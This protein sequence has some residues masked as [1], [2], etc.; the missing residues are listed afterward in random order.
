MLLEYKNGYKEYIDYLLSISLLTC[1]TGTKTGIIYTNASHSILNR[2]L[3]NP[4]E[5]GHD[6][7]NSAFE[8]ARSFLSKYSGIDVVSYIMFDREEKLK[9]LIG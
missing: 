3:M 2:F 7:Y 8:K 6:S 5:Y 9:L 1:K 4:A